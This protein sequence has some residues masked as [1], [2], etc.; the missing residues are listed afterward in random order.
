[1]TTP[2]AVMLLAAGIGFVVVDAAAGKSFR[3]IAPLQLCDAVVFIGAAALITRRQLLFELTY[4][5]GCSGTLAA[6]LTPD[7]YEDFPHFRFIFYFAQHGLIVVAAVLLAAGL[8]MR[9]RLSAPLRAIGWLNVYALFV[10][11]V[12]VAFKTNFMYL[13]H[14]PG[15]ATALD[16]FGPWPWY[17]LAS[18]GVA[19]MLFA[20]LMLPFMRA[21][22]T[23]RDRE[24][25]RNS[26]AAPPAQS[27]SD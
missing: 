12:N 24:A 14:K 25:L 13:R 16:V 7:L 20:L 21:L 2:V 11:L 1:M 3:S 4:L 23:D 6:L 8:G 19:L 27:E 15:A 22:R 17:I 10:G 5:W 26:S 9:P 18:E